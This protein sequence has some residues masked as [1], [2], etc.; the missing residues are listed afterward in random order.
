MA[1]KRQKCI[2]R[3][4]DNKHGNRKRA[5]TSTDADYR[6]HE[7]RIQLPRR[8]LRRTLRAAY[9]FNSRAQRRVRRFPRGRAVV[10]CLLI[11]RRRNPKREGAFSCRSSLFA[12]V[13]ISRSWVS[14]HYRRFWARCRASRKSET[15]KN[16]RIRVSRLSEDPREND[17][18]ST[19]DCPAWEEREIQDSRSRDRKF[20]LS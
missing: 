9:E 14:L 7:I 16:A 10:S 6:R 15:L 1:A 19:R 12:R 11:V 8:L 20:F 5:A 2:R 17:A 3:G 4:R 18:G 13:L